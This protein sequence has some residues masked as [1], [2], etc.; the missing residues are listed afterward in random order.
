MASTTHD[1]VLRAGPVRRRRPEPSR[2]DGD[3][4]VGVMVRL[5][6]E[7]VIASGDGQARHRV[8]GA[9][10]PRGCHTTKTSR[11][12]RR[13]WITPGPVI[14]GQAIAS[15]PAAPNR[16]QVLGNGAAHV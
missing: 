11:A 1:G 8:E 6:E 4:G 3:P 7:P 15:G 2:L 14:I 13:A 9:T 12:T 5:S 16:Q 10:G